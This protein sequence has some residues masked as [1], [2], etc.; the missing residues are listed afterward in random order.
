MA[1]IDLDLDPPTRVLRVFGW[2]ALV[3]FGGL[4]IAGRTLLGFPDGL[5]GVFAGLALVSALFSLMRP[6][7]NR[8]LYVVLSVVAYPIGLV[9][10]YVVL[11]ILF[12]GIFTPVGL[13]FRLI[14]R[15]ALRKRIDPRVETYWTAHEQVD[16]PEKYF[17]QF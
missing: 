14:G 3:A 9:M 8:P 7:L 4:A 1:V 15:D 6:S 2:G 13:L 12:Y 17:R 10:S 11:G 16:G 5:V